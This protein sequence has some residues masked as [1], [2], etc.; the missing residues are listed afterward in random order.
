MVRPVGLRPARLTLQG[1][2]LVA[3]LAACF[4]LGLHD[5][6]EACLPSGAGAPL[7]HPARGTSQSDPRPKPPPSDHT[8]TEA[9]AAPPCTL[10]TGTLCATGNASGPSNS[11]L[12]AQTAPQSKR[13]G[14]HVVHSALQK[15]LSDAEVAALLAAAHRKAN[16][17]DF[18]VWEL[19]TAA[20][21]DGFEEGCKVDDPQWRSTSTCGVHH[22]H[23]EYIKDDH[24]RP[25]QGDG[26]SHIIIAPMDHSIQSP[27]K[28]RPPPGWCCIVWGKDSDEAWQDLVAGECR[29]LSARHARSLGYATTQLQQT[30]GVEGAAGLR[31]AARLLA[32]RA[33][34][35]VIAEASSEF[36]HS[37]NQIVVLPETSQMVGE[38]DTD[39]LVV[40][41]YAHYDTTDPCLPHRSSR[42]PP[43]VDPYFIHSDGG[44]A[45]YLSLQQPVFTPAWSP[46][47]ACLCRVSW[48]AILAWAG[49][50]RMLIF[51]PFAC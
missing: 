20:N 13:N 26:C 23:K 24:V 41:P 51:P 10:Q 45:R 9:P 11:R 32:I 48:P 34:A 28:V 43:E 4:L 39:G 6:D 47:S 29:V 1:G 42:G 16:A 22:I 5:A 44:G 7:P 35:A 49:Q 19:E 40:D 12:V 3:L 50:S 46:E 8:P 37:H 25:P 18:K 17:P 30:R 15:L 21:A 38:W 33:G 14:L 31:M 27:G 36:M 2:V